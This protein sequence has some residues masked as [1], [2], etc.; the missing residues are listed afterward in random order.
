MRSTGL[1]STAPQKIP[2]DHKTTHRAR[3]CPRL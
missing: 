3:I 2:I 1:S